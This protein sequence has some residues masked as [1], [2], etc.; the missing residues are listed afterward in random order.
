MRKFL[1]STVALFGISTAAHAMEFNYGVQV[2]YAS[3]ESDVDIPAYVQPVFTVDSDGWSAGAFA[4]VDWDVSPGWTLGVEGDL[5]WTNGEGDALS[6]GG[7]GETFEIEQNWNGS[8][9]ARTAFDISPTNEIYGTL[10]VAWADMDAGYGPGAGSSDSAT[11]QGWTGGVGFEHNFGGW[12]GR[13]EYRYT[14][15]DEENFSALF[16][17]AD[18]TT[19]AIL[20]SAGWTM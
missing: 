15:Y 8:L 7:G 4:G 9:R 16:A 12:F 1:L 19:N 3:S 10:G 6:G 13:V 20:L 17:S 2:G 11:L 5:N 14:A 18:L